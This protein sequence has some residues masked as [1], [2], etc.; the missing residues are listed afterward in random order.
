M[1]FTLVGFKLLQCP[2][3]G[4]F[5]KRPGLCTSVNNFIYFFSLI[6]SRRYPEN[7][8]ILLVPGAGSILFY[9]PAL[10][11]IGKNCA[12]CIGVLLFVEGHLE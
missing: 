6:M 5:W 4:V 1:P 2:G 9:S 10:V 12:L 3:C 8:A 7:P 11:G